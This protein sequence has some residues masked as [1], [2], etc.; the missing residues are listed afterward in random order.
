MMKENIS[1][2]IGRKL[3]GVLH[4]HERSKIKRWVEGSPENLTN[5]EKIEEFWNK[6]TVITDNVD[7][8]SKFELLQRRIQNYEGQVILKRTNVLWKIAATLFLLISIGSVGLLVKE[9]S[10]SSFSLSTARGQKSE[11]ILPDG[12]KVWLNS[13]TDLFVSDF[14][15]HERVVKL[16]GGAYF[17]VGKDT[18][19]PFKVRLDGAQITVVG[20]EFNVNA[21]PNDNKID[22]TLIEGIVDM[23]VY[24]DRTYRMSPGQ[25]VIINKGNQEVKLISEGI[26]ESGLW[27]DGVLI[28][29]NDSFKKIMDVLQRQYGVEIVYK[30]EDFNELHYTGKFN[31]LELDQILEFINYSLP[32]KY[33]KNDKIYTVVR[34]YKD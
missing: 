20:T 26:T 29:N 17:K 7:L 14:T 12:T 15:K 5:F 31:N 11:A 1:K 13:E 23:E 21:Y 25:K 22:A 8:T 2:I 16:S 27:R 24:N 6:A 19:R 4:E 34:V 30:L 10:N 32:I 28:F 18:K 3:T 9:Q 33:T